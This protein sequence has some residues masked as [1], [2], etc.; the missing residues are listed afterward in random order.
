MVVLDHSVSVAA[1]FAAT[2]D[3]KRY[4][5]YA[6][7]AQQLVDETSKAYADSEGCPNVRLAHEYTT[8]DDGATQSSGRQRLDDLFKA[9]AFVNENCF[10]LSERQMSIIVD[11]YMAASLLQ[12]FG[13]DIVAELPYLLKRFKLRKLFEEV[14]VMMKRRGGKTVA[15]AVWVAIFLCTQPTAN[16]NIYGK[17]K[18]VSVMMKDLV[19][20]LV[21]ALWRSGLF[22]I[23]RIVED[24]E[25]T[26]SVET[27]YGTINVGKFYPCNEEVRFFSST[28]FCLFVFVFW[29]VSVMPWQW[30]WRR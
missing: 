29:A 25:E 11:N 10:S 24:N 4:V 6:S 21:I 15:T 16:T 27:K 1:P 2:L 20:D 18:R 12:I 5:S 28:V 8:R 23:V 7:H 14:I 17:S 19:K 13:G 9:L 26:L 22:G 30:Q 3:P